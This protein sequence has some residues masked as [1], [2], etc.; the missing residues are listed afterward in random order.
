MTRVTVVRFC[1]VLDARWV[2]ALA[3]KLTGSERVIVT[4]MGPFEA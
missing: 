2:K 4:I 1:E 3:G